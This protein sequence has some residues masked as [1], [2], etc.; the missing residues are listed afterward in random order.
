MH[1]TYP[2][3]HHKHG[4][5]RWHPRHTH[6]HSPLDK[7]INDEEHDKHQVHQAMHV[8]ESRSINKIKQSFGIM[9]H[10]IIHWIMDAVFDQGV[11]ALSRAIPPC[12]DDVGGTE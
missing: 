12:F 7:S 2:A 9:N 1:F 6:N 4:N 3:S 8:S 5:H 10:C 11:E